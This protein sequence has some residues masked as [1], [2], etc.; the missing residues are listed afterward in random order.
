MPQQLKYVAQLCMDNYFQTYKG[1]NDFWEL[2]DFISMCGSTIAAMYLTFY[3]TEYNMLRQEK[4]DEVISFDSGWLLEQEVEVQKNGIGLYATLNKPVM[5]FPYDKNSIGLQNIFI[6]DPVSPDELERTSLGALWQL[7]YIPKTNRIF[8]YSDTGSGS[9]L[10]ISKIG[11][12]NKGNCNIKK[13]RVLYVPSM[14]D[15]DAIVADG[16]ISDAI[17]KTV[18]SMRQMANGNVIDQTADSN[19][20]KIMQTEIDKNTLNK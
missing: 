11:I 15:G 20:N 6:T 5:T 13:I 9:C 3:T 14:Q 18:L 7:K 19:S 8:F 1:E 4:K 2:D 12:I 10:T 16:I 17:S